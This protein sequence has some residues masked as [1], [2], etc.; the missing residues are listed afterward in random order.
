ML[1]VVAP[2]TVKPVSSPATPAA[3]PSPAG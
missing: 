3:S 1:K 2:P